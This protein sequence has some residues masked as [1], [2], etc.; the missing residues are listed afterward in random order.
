[1]IMIILVLL[2]VKLLKLR[3]KLFYKVFM[4]YKKYLSNNIQQALET[5]IK[6]LNWG[7]SCIDYLI[8]YMWLLSRF[9]HTVKHNRIVAGYLLTTLKVLKKKKTNLLQFTLMKPEEQILFYKK[10]LKE[11]CLDLDSVTDTI[12]GLPSNSSDDTNVFNTSL[13]YLPE[14]KRAVNLTKGDVKNIIKEIIKHGQ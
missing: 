13:Q 14:F 2:G 1:M 9:D 7:H 4:I 11:G 10:I 3:N 6:K 5:L 8:A 12:L